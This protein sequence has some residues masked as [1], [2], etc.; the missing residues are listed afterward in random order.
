MALTGCARSAAEGRAKTNKHVSIPWFG[1]DVAQKGRYRCQSVRTRPARAGSLATGLCIPKSARKVCPTGRFF[2]CAHAIL[3]AHN[4]YNPAV[5]ANPSSMHPHCDRVRAVFDFFDEL[6]EDDGIC[7]PWIV[8][9]D[10]GPMLCHFRADSVPADDP[11]ETGIELWVASARDAA[12]P[13]RACPSSV[14]LRTT[15]YYRE[16]LAEFV[17]ECRMDGTFAPILVVPPKRPGFVVV[18]FAARA[19][20]DAGTGHVGDEPFGPMAGILGGDY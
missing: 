14:T 7:V 1:A 2:F 10:T 6:P 11:N 4:C 9:P 20:G 8:H 5:P 16:L 12:C 18:S 17:A 3:R 19:S 15:M 13:D